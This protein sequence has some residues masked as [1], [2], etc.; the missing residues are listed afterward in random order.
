MGFKRRATVSSETIAEAQWSAM[1][2]DREKQP[3]EAVT[4]LLLELSLHSGDVYGIVADYQGIHCCEL[5]QDE[6]VRSLEGLQSLYAEERRLRPV[7]ENYHC[8]LFE[9]C[10]D[11]L[12]LAHPAQEPQLREALETLRTRLGLP[13][14]GE[15]VRTDERL[16]LWAGFDAKHGK[17]YLSRG[18]IDVARL[19]ELQLQ[20]LVRAIGGYFETQRALLP[21]RDEQTLRRVCIYGFEWPA[22]L[23]NDEESLSL[24][25]PINR[26]DDG[27]YGH[28]LRFAILLRLLVR[29][30][31][32]PAIT[33]LLSPGKSLETH[34]GGL[35]TSFEASFTKLARSMAS[36]NISEYL[37][38]CRK[39]LGAD[40]SWREYANA[41]ALRVPRADLT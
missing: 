34:F 19:E 7:S 25:L 17:A 18:H 27:L 32:H 38:S 24:R 33:A 9:N 4:D 5:L 36:E 11:D 12:E 26:I 1:H 21:P 20:M 16:I 31:T 8:D 6:R 14:V 23:F 35:N 15:L 10:R 22:L 40:K 2:A 39:R 37:A 3:G 29:L 41:F 30:E 28:P 13:Y